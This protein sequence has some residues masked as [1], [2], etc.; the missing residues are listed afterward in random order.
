MSKSFLADVFLLHL[1]A[2][3]LFFLFPPCHDNVMLFW[4]MS[5]ELPSR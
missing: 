5:K 4:R 2:Y 1:H 3:N